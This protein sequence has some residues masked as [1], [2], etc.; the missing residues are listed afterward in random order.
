MT[1]VL[2]FC[3][4][5]GPHVST[6][7]VDGFDVFIL[8]DAVEDNAAACLEICNAVFEDHRSYRDAHVHLVFCK[9]ESTDGA[10]IHA[11]SILLEFVDDFNCLD[12]RCS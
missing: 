11:S 2:T 4:L 6:Q 3:L 7:L 12:L 1:R 5:D 8:L 10:G 9:V